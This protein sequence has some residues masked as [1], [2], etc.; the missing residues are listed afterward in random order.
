MEG[1][2]DE[3]SVFDEANSMSAVGGQLDQVNVLG[4]ILLCQICKSQFKDARFLPCHHY[5]CRSCIEGLVGSSDTHTFLCPQ[6]HMEINLP[7]NGTATLPVA[8]VVERI[9]E[10]IRS[11]SNATLSVHHVCQDHGI[12]LKLY[13]LECGLLLCPECALHHHG[14][15]PYDYVTSVAPM[16]MESVKQQFD[17]LIKIKDSSESHVRKIESSKR[18]LLQSSAS[19]TDTVNQCFDEMARHIEDRRKAI[20]D[21]L[22]SI[23]QQQVELY[24][25]QESILVSNISQIEELKY[26]WDR[27][28]EPSSGNK[29]AVVLLA[30]LVPQLK[31]KAGKMLPPTLDSCETINI[32]PEMKKVG[33]MKTLCEYIKINFIRQADSSTAHALVQNL[34]ATMELGKRLSFSISA[35][36]NNFKGANI[37]AF[38]QALADNSCTPLCVSKDLNIILTPVV[39]GRHELTVEVNGEHVTGSPFS[40]FVTVPME[41]LHNPVRDIGGLTAPYALAFNSKGNMV[42]AH[43]H[44]HG[45][46]SVCCKQGR[47]A[48]EV[49][50]RT[51]CSPSGVAVDEQD[52]IYVSEGKNHCVMKFHG[53]DGA[54]V[55]TIGRYGSG[56]GEFNT[57]QGLKVIEGQ[58]YVCDMGN[59][60]VQIFSKQLEFVKFFKVGKGITDIACSKQSGR[61]YLSGKNV[62]VLDR[63]HAYLFSIYDM[64][65]ISVCF[66]EKQNTLCLADCHRN[67]LCVINLDTDQVVN[68]FLS[69]E[70]CRGVNRKRPYGT[71]ID[72]DGYIYVCDTTNGR[73][74]VF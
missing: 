67:C 17:T 27:V 70:D 29:G 8:F 41:Q 45:R 68:R 20:L 38:V 3:A 47:R 11:R 16:Y 21:E 42:V 73:I 26:K 5:F 30:E 28:R 9:R 15:H 2:N 50:L 18:Y 51:L 7:G 37:R 54:H 55:K 52:D 49:R 33:E 10:R 74:L 56:L 13:C 6:C 64:N 66:N 63:D 35:R 24:Q 36:G 31:Q 19:V 60:R 57:P 12:E 39:R 43:S 61:F 23:V 71:A 34:P 69:T 48:L 22:T 65:S 62:E 46:I 1:K 25:R 40:L 44:P 14:D 72:E 58:L 32:V 53:G 59:S 4:E